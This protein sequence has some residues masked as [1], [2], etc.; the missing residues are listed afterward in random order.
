MCLSLDL[1]KIPFNI[2]INLNKAILKINQEFDIL[3][4]NILSY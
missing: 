1:L 2:L 3:I 4:K